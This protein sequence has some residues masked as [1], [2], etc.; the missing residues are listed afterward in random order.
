MVW[1]VNGRRVIGYDNAEGK[2]HHRHFRGKEEPY[3]FSSIAKT[4][5]DYW[6]DVSRELDKEN[7]P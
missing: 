7:R 1:I 6:A 5:E 4:F 3:R 2:G